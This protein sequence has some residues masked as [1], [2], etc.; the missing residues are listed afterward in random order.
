MVP[1]AERKMRGVAFAGAG[2][3]DAGLGAAMSGGTTVT[4][5]AGAAA[6]VSAARLASPRRT[7]SFEPGIITIPATRTRAALPPRS[8]RRGGAGQGARRAFDRPRPAQALLWPD[9]PHRTAARDRIRAPVV[10]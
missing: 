3:G 2:A 4:T 8:G 9:C 10:P 1:S 6:T 7:Q 5:G